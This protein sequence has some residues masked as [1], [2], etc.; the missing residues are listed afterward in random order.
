V[1]VAVEVMMMMMMRIVI[2][3]LLKHD[4][5]KANMSVEIAGNI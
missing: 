2:D 3:K 1:K 5:M 4:E